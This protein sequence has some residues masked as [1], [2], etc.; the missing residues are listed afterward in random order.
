[1]SFCNKERRKFFASLTPKITQTARS[2]NL[3]RMR[4]VE[5]PDEVCLGLI[6][7]DIYGGSHVIKL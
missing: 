1:M 7:G 4:Y 6:R 3:I 2:Y 5:V